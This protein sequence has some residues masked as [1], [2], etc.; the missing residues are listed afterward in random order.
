MPEATLPDRA[1]A[2]QARD[3]RWWLRAARQN[4]ALVALMLAEFM[5]APVIWAI[6]Q[7][8]HWL[9][10]LASI[11]LLAPFRGQL[12]GLRLKQARTLERA[13]EDAER[14][15]RRRP[16][17]L[18]LTEAPTFDWRSPAGRVIIR[19]A[20]GLSVFTALVL[21]MLTY[22]YFVPAEDA[23]SSGYPFFLAGATLF[24]G[25]FP[26]YLWVLE[27]RGTLHRIRQVLAAPDE[28]TLI[29]V[30]G[31]DPA[32][33]RWV[34]QRLDDGSRISVRLIG[35]TQLLVAGDELPAQG[36]IRTPAKNWRRATFPLLA[37]STPSGTL[38]ARHLGDAPVIEPE[39]EPAG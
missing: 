31:I 28:R 10:L 17:G 38:W 3:R 25:G 18:P 21:V 2:E 1:L 29:E 5:L 24:F 36:T 35:G 27:Y 16:V 19:R 23:D 37:L 4:P 32:T 14:T 22:I 9:K 7:P 30:V 12:R 13:D 34:L 26:V 6:W 20:A 11:L 39:P 33:G 15:G 8:N